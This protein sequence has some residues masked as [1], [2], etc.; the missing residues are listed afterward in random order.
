MN[1][2]SPSA[3]SVSTQPVFQSFAE[4]VARVNQQLVA[5]GTLPDGLDMRA[6]TV[7]PPGGSPTGGPTG[8]VV[9]AGDLIR[10]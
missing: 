2:T 4:A 3:D 6:V 10:E 5:A 9:Y 7:E 8:P 1:T